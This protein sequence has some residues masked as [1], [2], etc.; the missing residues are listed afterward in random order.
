MFGEAAGEGAGMQNHADDG[1]VLTFKVQ[2]YLFLNLL[3]FWSPPELLQKQFPSK[4]L[5]MA[6][7]DH[8]EVAVCGWQ[9]IKIQILITK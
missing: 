5:F 3:G 9:N 4:F 1:G 8:S 7:S 2:D 6:E